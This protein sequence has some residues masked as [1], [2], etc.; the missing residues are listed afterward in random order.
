MRNSKKTTPKHI[1][2]K[3]LKTQRQREILKAVRR[4]N[5]TFRNNP[6]VLRS[7]FSTNSQSQKTKDCYF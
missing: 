3:L 5:N 2:V 6:V 1:I 4:R 7:D